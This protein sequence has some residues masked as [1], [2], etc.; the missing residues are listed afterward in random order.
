MAPDCEINAKSPGE[1]KLAA[2]LALSFRPGTR[3][4]RQLGPTSRTPFAR[5]AHSAASD[6]DRGPWPKPAVRMI[7][8]AQPLDPTAAINSGTLAGGVAIIARSGVTGR[9]FIVLTAATPSISL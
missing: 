5:A 7:A 4:P 1:G 9:S 8:A 2:K 3:T 6:S